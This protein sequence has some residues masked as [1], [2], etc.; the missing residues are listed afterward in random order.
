MH[1]K[2]FHIN[3]SSQETATQKIHQMLSVEQGSFELAK[4]EHFDSTFN[5]TTVQPNSNFP[6]YLLGRAS[7]QTARIKLNVI[8]LTNCCVV[9]L[10]LIFSMPARD[11]TNNLH[12]RQFQISSQQCLATD[13]CN[14]L[15]QLQNLK[16]IR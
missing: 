13:Y 12:M 8:L 7:T 5:I 6:R 4:G 16:D 2:Y 3:W 1:S 15:H 14:S 11:G 9:S 10:T